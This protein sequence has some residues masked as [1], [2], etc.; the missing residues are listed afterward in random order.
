VDAVNSVQAASGAMV[1]RDGIGLD[2]VNA[3]NT[4]PWHWVVEAHEFF[5]VPPYLIRFIRS[6]LSD[7]RVGYTGKDGER[8]RPIERGVPFQ[9]TNSVDHRL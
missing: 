9:R 7:R 6:Y 5:E 2:I 1:F 4:I 3:F 8:R